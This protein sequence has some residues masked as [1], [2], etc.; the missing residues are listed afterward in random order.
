MVPQAQTRNHPNGDC[1]RACLA[2]LLEISI[3]LVPD[4]TAL[5]DDSGDNELPRWYVELQEFCLSYG[6]LF[7]EVQLDQKTLFP[8][9]KQLWVICIGPHVTGARHAIVAVQIG[10]KLIPVFDPMNP[11]GKPEDAFVGRRVDAL[12]Y[13]VPIDPSQLCIKPDSTGPSIVVRRDLPVILD[14][15]IDGKEHE[16]GH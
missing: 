5:P 9:P 14:G 1:I 13:L 7:I 8:V 4:F 12:A 2:S 10:S 16:A 15:P 6:Y 11:K 3:N